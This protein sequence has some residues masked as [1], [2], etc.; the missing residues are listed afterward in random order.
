MLLLPHWHTEVLSSLRLLIENSQQALQE[1][2]E[3]HLLHLVPSPI[4]SAI[5]PKNALTAL[6]SSSVS[7]VSVL[8]LSSLAE[9]SSSSNFFILPGL[10][11]Q[12]AC[13]PFHP[14][15]SNY[16]LLCPFL[17]LRNA[18]SSSS[19]NSSPAA[20]I[21]GLITSSSCSVCCVSFL[22]HQ[23]LAESLQILQNRLM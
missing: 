2:K 22:V 23:L 21:S 3:L 16:H 1:Q 14:L 20:S 5:T 6:V 11:F 4:F 17:G 10:P 13:P 8:P 19:V 9:L 18:S 15:Q 12:Q 7:S